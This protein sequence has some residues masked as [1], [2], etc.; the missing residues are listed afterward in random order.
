[1]P[2]PEPS[3]TCRPS[4]HRPD[5]R[6]PGRLIRPLGVTLTAVLLG[7]ILWPTAAT[8]ETAADTVPPTT[9]GIPTVV[10]ISTTGV[11]LTWT[12]ATDNVGVTGYE[13]AQRHTDY[14]LIRNASGNQITIDG[15]VP[16]Y[17]YQFS[18][19]ARDAA[20]NRSPFGPT[21]RLTMPP[22]DG[23]PPT[24][25]ANPVATEV[26]TDSVTLRWTP[27]TDNVYVGWYEVLRVHPDGSTTRVA[28]AP[29]H[30]PTGPTA[31]V[32]GLTAGTTYTFVVRAHDDAGNASPLSDP[33][34]VTTLPSTDTCEVAYQVQHS[35]P[36][37]FQTQV[38]I[39]NLSPKTIDGWTL[40]W[41]FSGDQRIG[42]LWGAEPVDIVGPD[43]TVRNASWT[44]RIESGGS[45]QFGFIGSQSTS[46]TPPTGFVLNGV[47][48]AAAG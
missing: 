21:L 26:G 34:T 30:P 45:I 13:V 27:S 18:V 36:G 39:R 25:P 16:S 19:S 35:W 38:T 29:Q 9:P 11:T 1:M 22:G 3:L 48:C 10:A 7:L 43:I 33:L 37:A 40:S 31:R 15:L 14:I 46:N 4:H 12:A 42:Q 23:Q 32:S 5:R 8:A 44:S 47:D 17:T 2:T 28:T 6:R 41:T 20:G 24:A